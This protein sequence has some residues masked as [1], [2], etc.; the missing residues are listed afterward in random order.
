M[1]WDHKTHVQTSFAQFVFFLFEKSPKGAPLAHYIALG[2]I[3]FVQ[4]MHIANKSKH[5]KLD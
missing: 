3:S 4:L 2:P 5:N 1:F